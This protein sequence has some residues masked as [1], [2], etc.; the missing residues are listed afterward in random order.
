MGLRLCPQLLPSVPGCFL[1]A[2]AAEEE[3]LRGDGTKRRQAQLL[4]P[5]LLCMMLLINP[6]NHR[7]VKMQQPNSGPHLNPDHDSCYVEGEEGESEGEVVPVG[8]D[9]ARQ[10]AVGA[11]G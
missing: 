7:C 6:L 8:V 2:A 4:N 3:P 11:R 10:E 9:R 1:C 5:L